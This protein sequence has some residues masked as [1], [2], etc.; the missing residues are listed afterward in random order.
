M[1][2]TSSACARLGRA[3][4]RAIEA[5]HAEREEEEIYLPAGRAVVCMGAMHPLVVWGC[6]N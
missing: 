3:S 2:H 6:A 1:C 4:S 5:P